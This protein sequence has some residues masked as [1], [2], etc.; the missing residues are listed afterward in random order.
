MR[1]EAKTSPLNGA[2][3]YDCSKRRTLLKCARCSTDDPSE[4]VMI[5]AFGMCG[6]CT[7]M[8]NKDD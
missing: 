5:G 8:M 3:S 2:S 6:Y 7:Y 1:G 4:Q